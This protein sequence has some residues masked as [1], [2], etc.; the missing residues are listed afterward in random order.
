MS[1]IHS[2]FE[3]FDPAK[4][5]AADVIVIAGDITELGCRRPWEIERATWWMQQLGLSTPVLWIPGNHDFGLH[6][7]SFPWTG[8][9]SID[10]MASR[11][12]EGWPSFYGVNM[13][14]CYNMPQIASMWRDMTTR[15]EVEQAAF[16]RIPLGT[17]VIV[18]HCPP[19]GVL[20]MAADGSH[21]GSQA[22]LD[23]IHEIKPKLVICGHVHEA[24]GKALVGGTW[25][26]NVACGWAVIDTDRLKGE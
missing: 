22:L 19:F 6:P 5:P 17:D 11:P 21:I 7:L 20:D 8:A 1:D 18:S 26:Y 13:S 16:E 12:R 24:A 10:Q 15:P 2:R 9:K 3:K 23:K 14:P 4:L 25:V